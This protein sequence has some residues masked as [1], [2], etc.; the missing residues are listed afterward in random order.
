MVVLYGNPS[1]IG[2]FAKVRLMSLSGN[3]FRAEE[4]N[5]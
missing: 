5:E 3:T 2:S 4:V 1:R